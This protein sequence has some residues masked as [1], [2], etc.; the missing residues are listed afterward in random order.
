MLLDQRSRHSVGF[1]YVGQDADTREPVGTAFFVS[2]FDAGSNHIY[3]VTAGH[4]IDGV[5]RAGGELYLRA[6]SRDDSPY[7]I[8]VPVESWRLGADADVAVALVTD[9]IDADQPTIRFQDELVDNTF[10]EDKDIDVGAG[11]FFIGLFAPG[12]DFHSSRPI[13]RFGNIALMPEDVPIDHG[14]GELVTRRVYLVEARSW[15]GHSGSPAFVYFQSGHGRANQLGGDPFNERGFLPGFGRV[16]G[17]VSGHFDVPMP[18]GPG[19]AVELDNEK[20]EL[21]VKVN[22]GIAA[23]TPSQAII[24]LLGR[25]DLSA[26]RRG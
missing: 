16:L 2:L 12:Q 11:V 21:K 14:D 4:I 15:A 19:L 9:A 6:R 5:R 7:F 17:V 1:L 20:L 3:A 13:A 25:E 26:A 24:D 23:V 8:S 10:A 22:S 18:V